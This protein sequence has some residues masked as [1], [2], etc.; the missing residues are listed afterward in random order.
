MN[1]T[2][3]AVLI[4]STLVVSWLAMQIIH[5]L[6]HVLGAKLSGGRVA[7]VVLHPTTISYTR[8]AENPR[9]LFVTWM[10]PLVGAMLPVIM[11]MLAK[12]LRW[13]AAYLVQFFTG[14]CLI[15]NGAYVAFGSINA[16]GDAG[17][18]LKHGASRLL[19]WLFGLITIITGLMLWHGLGQH[20]GLGHRQREV[21]WRHACSMLAILISIVTTEIVLSR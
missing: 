11:L 19:I 20:F 18:L 4:V 2:F 3:Q 12:A 6:G 16:V 21:N 15:A 14:F 1:R 7:E 9:P 8:L 5:E 17:D 10:G 13:S